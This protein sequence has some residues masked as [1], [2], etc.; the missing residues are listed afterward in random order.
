MP[1]VNSAQRRA[2]MY[3]E[4]DDIRAG[5]T[6]RWDC[7]KFGKILYAGRLRTV[8]LTSRGAKYINVRGK[9]VYVYNVY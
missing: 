5:R 6:I 7:K 1:F 4:Q 8:Y 2:C 3:K 9:K